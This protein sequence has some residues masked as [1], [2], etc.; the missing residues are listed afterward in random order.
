LEPPD[1]LALAE[2]AVEILREQEHFRKAARTQAEKAL[3]LDK[4]VDA[5]LKFLF[6]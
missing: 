3:G 1:I 4:M 2:A 6:D 5:Y